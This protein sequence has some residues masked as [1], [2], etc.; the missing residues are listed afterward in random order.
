[1]RINDIK[2]LII[3]LLFRTVGT[4]IPNKGERDLAI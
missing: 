1:M 2:T 4:F 3:D